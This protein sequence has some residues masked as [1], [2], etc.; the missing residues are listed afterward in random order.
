MNPGHSFPV[1][2]DREPPELVV[3]DEL[4]PCPYLPDREARMPLRLPIRPLGP[5]EWD[6]RLVAGDRRHGAVLYR[7]ACPDCSACEPIRVEVDRF[8]ESRNLRRV[9]RRAEREITI[10]LGPTTVDDERIEL[11]ERHL[12]GRGLR[13]SDH[14]PIDAV[15]FRHFLVE[16]CV[17]SFEVRYRHQGRLVGVACCDR[18]GAS[19]SAHY[20]YF[21]PDLAELSLGTYSIIK[22]IELCRRWKLDWFYLGLFIAENEH[23]SYKGR[24]RPHHRLIDGR[25]QVFENGA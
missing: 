14:T 3:A 25:W 21:D 12:D 7:T 18:G 6:G 22:Q 20:T 8:V 2:A 24:F 15:R 9:R 19:L 11:Y 1:V 13:Q 5:A 17:A 23:M 16:S 4:I 10:S